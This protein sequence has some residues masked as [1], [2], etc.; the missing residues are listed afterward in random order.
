M[1][2]NAYGDL[3]R[4]TLRFLDKIAR[5]REARLRPAPQHTFPVDGVK[6]RLRL[7]HQHRI[8]SE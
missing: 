8:R 1:Q 5:E 6:H 7:M 3:D 2:A 4:A